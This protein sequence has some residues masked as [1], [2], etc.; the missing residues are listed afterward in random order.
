MVQT[1]QLE[2]LKK[3]SRDLGNYIHKLNKR[4]RT[5]TAYRIAKKR[6]FLDAAIEQVENRV[7]G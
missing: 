4:G 3:D 5:D 7:R 1:N 2:R 6:S